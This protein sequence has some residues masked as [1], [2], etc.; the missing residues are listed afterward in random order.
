MN[1]LRKMFGMKEP[2]PPKAAMTPQPLDLKPDERSKKNRNLLRLNRLETA[3]KQTKD[4]AKI[5]SLQAEI[6]RRKATGK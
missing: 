5:K 3:I 2:E 1:W 4:P 6:D